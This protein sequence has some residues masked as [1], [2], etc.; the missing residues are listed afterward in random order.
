MAIG[1]INDLCDTLRQQG[2]LTPSQAMHLPRLAKKRSDVRSLA[3]ALARRGW[4]T[5]YQINQLF[6]A[7][8]D[9]LVIGSYIVLERLGQGGLSQVFKARHKEEPNW[10]VALKVL[11][12][13]VLA[14]AEGRKQFLEEMEAMARLDHPNIVQFCDLDQAVGTFYYTMEL[15]DGIDLGKHVELG[16]PLPVS[17]ACDY[18]RQTA[19]GLQH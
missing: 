3:K 15:I 18:I 17:E 4:L 8:G 9:E 19:L 14:C 6:A 12:P 7:E 16:G 10:I 5:I 11:R 2:L 13:A 1:S